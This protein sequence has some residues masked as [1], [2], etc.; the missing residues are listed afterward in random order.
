MTASMDRRGSTW[1]YQWSCLNISCRDQHQHIQ[2]QHTKEN[3]GRPWQANCLLSWWIATS[4]ATD[5]ACDCRWNSQTND[6][7]N[8]VRWKKNGKKQYSNP[9][10]G[11]RH[12][13]YLLQYFIHVTV[14]VFPIFPMVSKS[15]WMHWEIRWIVSDAFTAFSRFTAIISKPEPFVTSCHIMSCQ[16]SQ[17]PVKL[18][19]TIVRKTWRIGL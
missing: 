17:S 5:P 19:Q 3:L 4:A 7:I 6:T 14:C 15:D 13:L 18:S 16:I 1:L 12:I 10:P 9:S 8:T 2:H 11:R